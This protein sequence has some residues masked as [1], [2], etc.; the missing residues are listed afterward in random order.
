M[1]AVILFKLGGYGILQLLSKFLYFGIKI[2]FIFIIIRLLC[3]FINSL[4][5]IRQSDIKSSIAY[6]SVIH[7]DIVIRGLIIFYI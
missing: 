4:I 1:L 5:C 7:I 3:G 2:N 6:S